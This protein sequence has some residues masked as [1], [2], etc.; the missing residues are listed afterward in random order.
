MAT[1]ESVKGKIQGLISQANEATGK[2]DAD[3]TTAIGSL[4][5]GFGQGGGSGDGDESTLTKVIDGTA[6]VEIVD[7]QATIVRAS[8]FRECGNLVSV[9]LP[10]ATSIGNDAFNSC[11][12]LTTANFPVATSI[13]TYAFE[14]CGA[15]TTL[16]LRTTEKVATLFNTNAFSNTPIKSGTGYIYIPATLIDSYKAATNWS[17]FAAQFRALEDYTVDGTTTGELDPTKI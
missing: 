3:L 10:A 17:T 4:I 7:K 13:S 1:A 5:A 2:T 9:D 6:P 16:I 12:A 15:L 11:S 14:N 8:A